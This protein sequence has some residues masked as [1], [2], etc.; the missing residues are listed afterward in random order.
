MLWCTELPPVIDV[1]VGPINGA[2][3]QVEQSPGEVAP[4]TGTAGSNPAAAPPEP[5]PADSERVGTS[6]TTSQERPGTE[7]EG[8]AWVPWS[9]GECPVPGLTEVDV[10]MDG[11]TGI[12]HP[13]GELYWENGGGI[14]A[15]RLTNPRRRDV[16]PLPVV[17]PH[18]AMQRLWR[19][20]DTLRV[21]WLN[22]AYSKWVEA[23]AP[24]VW[25][26]S[27]RYHVGH[28]PPKEAA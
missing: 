4:I 21:W 22:P 25:A 28:V 7:R 10:S 17:H 27:V 11:L 26:G 13:A 19:S 1:T 5:T 2:A 14:T 12:S 3:R 9:G 8:K 6:T 23:I 18:Y 20:D 24:V 16:P 15:Y